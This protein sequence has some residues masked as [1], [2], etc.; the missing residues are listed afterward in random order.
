MNI[1][2]YNAGGSLAHFAIDA[3]KEMVFIGEE[4]IQLVSLNLDDTIDF[5]CGLVVSQGSNGQRD[6]LTG[7]FREIIRQRD[8][9]RSYFL[10]RIKQLEENST[11]PQAFLAKQT[12]MIRDDMLVVTTIGGNGDIEVMSLAEFCG[13]FEKLLGFRDLPLICSSGFPIE[14]LMTLVTEGQV[15]KKVNARRSHHE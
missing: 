1:F 7:M 4:S 3:G 13:E 6:A 14:A 12:T 8:I 15:H 9:E 2:C 10:K 5:V 11:R